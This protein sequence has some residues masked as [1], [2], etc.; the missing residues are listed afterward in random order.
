VIEP[1]F[2]ALVDVARGVLDELDLELALEKVL[3]SARELT[4]A[5]YAALGVLDE[6]RT[7]LAR[8]IA[9]GIDDA[10]RRQ[11]GPLP[12]G[13]GVLGE[14]IADP[15]PLR[16]ANVGAHPRSYGFPVGHPP[17]ASFLGVPILV[18]GKPFG[19]LYL[20]DKQGCD[21]FSQDDEDA[22]VLLAEFAGVAID[23]AR[24]FTGSETRRGEL[25]RTVE[26]LDATIQIGTALG[27]QMEL[28]TILEL[29]A[30]RGRALVSARALVIE[31][32][33][34]GELVVAA[35]AGHIPPDLVGSRV[36]M[37][38]T[39]ASQALRTGK[40]QRLEEEL[41]RIRFQ[42]HG[43]GHL[44]LEAECG[45]V[46]P[47]IFHGRQHGVLVAVDRLE[48]ASFTPQDLR[49]LESFAVSAAAAVDTAR[50]VAAERRS[51][52]LAAAEQ[53]RARW[54]RE[55]HDETLQGLAAV[56]VGLSS[57]RR[58]ADQ[59]AMTAA[60]DQAVEQLDGEIAGLRGLLTELRPAA[61]DELGTEAAI[62]AL[63]DRAAR[64]GLEVDVSIDLAYEQGRQQERPTPELEVAM[65]RIV[66][67]A[68]TNAMKHGHAKRAMIEL[69]EE[70]DV[71]R[72]TVRDDGEG[73][74]PTHETAGFGL[75]G[76]RERAEL[77]EAT[78]E[79]ASAPGEG[80]TI[81]ATFPVHRRDVVEAPAPPT[82][83][84]RTA[85]D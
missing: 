16:L 17:M 21:E 29:V 76:M 61:L 15:V 13:R 75:L 41:N 69:I 33:E 71:A 9:V 3:Q 43:L 24:R 47:L 37:E 10:T 12:K 70:D 84:R 57:A 82:Q 65:Y 18:A 42:Q 32:Q 4:G 44:G 67:E 60:M 66:Q 64:S 19:N 11:I 51:Q 50:S 7:E 80:T 31:L 35:A 56:R 2:R 25:E 52:R 30:K 45:L 49:L 1:A 72:L 27:G 68:L 34:G 55:L 6:S 26:A 79:I 74:D 20:T 59:Q 36:P 39:V 38:E 77:V 5:R 58:T 63:A 81:T 62:G 8:F 83:L 14:L 53:E 40:P 85:D 78:L 28:E 22:L 54:A 46:V 73:F 23:H 48:G